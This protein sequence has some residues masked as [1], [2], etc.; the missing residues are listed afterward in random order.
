[1]CISLLIM[2][3]ILLIFT[4]ILSLINVGFAQWEKASNGLWAEILIYF[5]M[6]RRRA[7]FMPGHPTEGF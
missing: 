6:I 2:K 3:R 7:G 5:L 4:L 1:M